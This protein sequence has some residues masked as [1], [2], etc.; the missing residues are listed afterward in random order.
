[1]ASKL[2]PGIIWATVITFLVGIYIIYSGSNAV[3]AGYVISTAEGKYAS[4]FAIFGTLWEFFGWLYMFLG[5]L[6]FVIGAGLLSLKEWARRNGVYMFWVIAILSFYHGVVLGFN[7]MT[8][9]ILPFMMLGISGAMALKLRSRSIRDDIEFH[10]QGS[11]YVRKG[12]GVYYSDIIRA[13]KE[14]KREKKMMMKNR[15]S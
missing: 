7:D 8:D 15:K 5:L 11:S 14:E 1:M 9:G 13:E 12:G 2:P 4:I 10:G 3:N 6:C